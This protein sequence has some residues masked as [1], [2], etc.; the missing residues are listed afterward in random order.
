MATD[1]FLLKTEFDPKNCVVDKMPAGTTQEFRIKAGE[2]MG[3]RFPK[4]A[5]MRMSKDYPGQRV[6]DAIANTF[7]FFMVSDRLKNVVAAMRPDAVEF[8]RFD[9]ENHKKAA[10][11]GDF[12]I[13]NLLGSI[14]CVDA[15]G[16]EG[17]KSSI[18]PDQY[19]LLKRL[20]IVASAVPKGVHLFR[21]GEMTS[22][23]VAS[24]AFVDAAKQAGV[25]GLRY[26]A[27]GEK[28]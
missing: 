3:T 25:R 10:V 18:E 21:L 11:A 19:L 24:A 14:A 6:T 23:I 15:K 27:M 9:L 7:D 5:A 17:K 26:I 4:R 12:W 8:L 22:K 28:I 1:F 20:Q 13:V 2:K 16:T